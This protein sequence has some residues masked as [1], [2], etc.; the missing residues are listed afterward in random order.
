MNN[1][2]LYHHG[3][4]GMKWGVRRYQN[5][6]GSLTPKGRKKVKASYIK[7]VDKINTDLSNTMTSRWVNANNKVYKDWKKNKNDA[8]RDKYGTREDY[9]DRRNR[10]VAKDFKNTLHADT[11]NFIENNKHYKKANAIIEKYGSGG[12]EDAVEYNKNVSD[13]ATKFNKLAYD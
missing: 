7:E 2:E 5:K 8:F 11:V 9:D 4:L 13:I 3:V 12:F 10:A 1:Y 6:D